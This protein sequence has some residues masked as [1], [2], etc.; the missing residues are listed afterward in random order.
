MSMSMEL[1]MVAV[2]VAAGIMLLMAP[3]LAVMVIAPILLT[4]ALDCISITCQESASVKCHKI[5]L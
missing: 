3:V 5:D 4:A 1:L 2:A